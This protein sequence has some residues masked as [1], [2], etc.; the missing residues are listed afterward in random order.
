MGSGN[1]PGVIE[2]L[3]LSSGGDSD[4]NVNY[5]EKTEAEHYGESKCIFYNL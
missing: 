4:R 1:G 5:K 3:H 2:F